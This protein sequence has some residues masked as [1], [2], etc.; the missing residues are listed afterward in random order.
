MSRRVVGALVLMGAASFLACGGEPQPTA[1]VEQAVSSSGTPQTVVKSLVSN[2]VERSYRILAPTVD[3]D[4]KLPMLIM[5]HGWGFSPEL[6]QVAIGYDEFALANH[7]I[8]VFPEGV[9]LSWNAGACCWP[10]NYLGVDDVQFISDLIDDVAASYRLDRARVYASGI[11]NGAEMAYRL[12]CERPD[13]IAAVGS[14]AGTL[15]QTCTPGRPVPVIEIH[16]TADWLLPY[17][18]GWDIFGNPVIGAPATVGFWAGANGCDA[19]KKTTFSSADVTC[20]QYKACMAGAAVELC[21][22]NGGGHNWPGAA[23]DLYQMDPVNNWWWGYQTN[24]LAAH[25]AIWNFVKQY[26]LP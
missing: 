3:G 6:S 12:A 21:T 26:H 19:N 13:L 5:M 8:S 2:G 7:F 23:L 11:S 15:L 20:E 24:E 1:G 4:P 10:A 16:G 22:V 25:A 14:V 9:G 18:G 17:D